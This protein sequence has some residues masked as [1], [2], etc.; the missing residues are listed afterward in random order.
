MFLKIIYIGISIVSLATAHKGY[1][2]FFGPHQHTNGSALPHLA[3]SGA[4]MILG[5]LIFTVSV[6]M[7]FGF[8]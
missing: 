5:W 8:I 2:L 6:S 7:V 3:K 4:M 1:R